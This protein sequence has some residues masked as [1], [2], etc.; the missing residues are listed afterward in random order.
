MNA[1]V[2]GPRADENKSGSERMKIEPILGM[3]PDEFAALA[4]SVFIMVPHRADDGVTANIMLNTGFWARFGTSITAIRDDFG[5]F[6]E[7]TRA[8]MVKMFRQV[9]E[10]NPKIKYLVM[11]DNDEEVNWDAPYQLAAWDLPIVSGIICSHAPT[12]GIF[13]NVFIK[14]EFGVA[15]MPSFNR[16]GKIPGK[17]LKECHSVGTGL[18][19]IRFDVFEKIIEAGDM[20]FVMT[21]EDR[22]SCFDT[23]VL[24]VGEDTTFCAQARKQGFKCFVDF[25]V[26]GKHFKTLAVEWPHSHIDDSIDVRTWQVDPGDYH[27]G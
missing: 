21:L 24:K 14:D 1:L 6:I 10:D 25:A 8:N 22:Q 3:S 20:P 16:T 18:L 19:C 23:G 17:G 13:A 4:E 27:H 2:I 5:G 12:R 15:R 7:M 9:R 11:I 26:R